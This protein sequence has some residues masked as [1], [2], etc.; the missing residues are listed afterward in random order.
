MFEN[1]RIPLDPTDVCRCVWIVRDYEKYIEQSMS[2]VAF[3][4]DILRMNAKW[5]SKNKAKKKKMAA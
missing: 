4:D 3:D 1:F 2:F 5:A